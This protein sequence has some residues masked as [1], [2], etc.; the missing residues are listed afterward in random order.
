MSSADSE[1]SS[2]WDRREWFATTHWSVVLAAGQSSSPRAR[3]ALET[4]CQGYWAPLYSF[5]RRLG[6]SPADAQDLTQ[7]FLAHL[8]AHHSLKNVSAERGR[9]RSFL[10]GALKHFLADEWDKMR[11][12]KRGG[13]APVVSLDA[14][15]AEERNRMEPVDDDDPEKI[16]ERRWALTL[17]DRVLAR[18]E[19]EIKKAGR[20]FLWPEMKACL[21]ADED[22]PPYAELAKQLG[23]TPSAVKMSV[24]RL[25]RRYAEMLRMEVAATVSSD[26]ELE[27]EMG[28]LLAVL[29]R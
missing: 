4:L 28:Y 21:L 25:R 20:D 8:L 18:L 16:Y 11:A 3:E 23:V 14:F 10:L 29:G 6:H 9:F 24:L 17:L 15:E 5:I 1:R 19:A 26:S 13:G 2:T 22:S 7:A 27:E 12:K